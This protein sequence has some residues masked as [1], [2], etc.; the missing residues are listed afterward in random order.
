MVI[1]EPAH[2]LTHARTHTTR[3]Q[4]GS[5]STGQKY[6]IGGRQIVCEVNTDGVATTVGDGASQAASAT[7]CQSILDHYGLTS[8]KRWVRGNQVDLLSRCRCIQI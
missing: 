2:T 6:W 1:D 4:Y 3:A 5:V 7:S 8:E